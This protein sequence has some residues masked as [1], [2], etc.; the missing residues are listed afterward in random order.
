MPARNRHCSFSYP[1]LDRLS[2]P[3]TIAMQDSSRFDQEREFLSLVSSSDIG[4]LTLCHIP[5]VQDLGALDGATRRTYLDIHNRMIVLGC[6][7]PIVKDID[8]RRM[9]LEM[10]LV[11]LIQQ[12]GLE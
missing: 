8:N 3:R 12:E 6:C 2:R 10:F 1:D 4:T 9:S 11:K 7:S 5:R